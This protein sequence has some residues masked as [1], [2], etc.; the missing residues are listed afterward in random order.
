M[1]ISGTGKVG[2]GS[3]IP[4]VGLSNLADGTAYNV[5]TKGIYWNCSE[6]SKYAAQFRNGA[7]P[8]WGIA[9]KLGIS[10]PDT[11]DKYIDFIDDQGTVQA[12]F[13]GTGHATAGLGI[14]TGGTERMRIDSSGNVGIRE[15][16]T[17]ATLHLKDIGGTSV[18]LALRH[19]T[20][21]IGK[22]FMARFQGSDTG[23]NV[24][25]YGEIKNEI[26]TRAV[27]T[28]SGDFVFKNAESGT[29]TET[30]RIHAGGK[31][32]LGQTG[33]LYETIINNNHVASH[34][35]RMAQYQNVVDATAG[36]RTFM[37][38][39]KWWWS[40]GNMIIHI[41]EVSYGPD[42][43]Y[44]LF[45]VNGHTRSDDVTIGTIFNPVT[46]G[47]AVPTPTIANYDGTAENC[48]LQ[49]S[50]AGYRK[51]VIIVDSYN[52]AYH[53]TDTNVG[54]GNEYHFYNSIGVVT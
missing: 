11:S 35:R 44:G 53:T 26:V 28:Q 23:G 45:Q 34:Q 43:N 48:E 4:D 14:Q 47:L 8:A 33:T 18:G 5:G 19:A 37:K 27:G 54:A 25:D 24:V 51:Y 16:S 9:V 29:L 42:S 38:Y 6:A 36:T 50:M 15:A 49:I 31:I 10:A 20:N 13:T 2:I 46:N 3:H 21:D 32:A 30:M 39:A 52:M 41:R 17:G 7:D 22:G 40:W 12:S 1:T